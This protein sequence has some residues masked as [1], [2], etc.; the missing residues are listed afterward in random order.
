MKV[1]HSIGNIVLNTDLPVAHSS[2]TTVPHASNRTLSLAASA[3]CN[4]LECSPN[5]KT[6]VPSARHDS[7]GISPLVNY[8]KVEVAQPEYRV[9]L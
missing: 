5:G 9:I 6:S 2:P 3:G 1:S 4:S 8:T 7:R